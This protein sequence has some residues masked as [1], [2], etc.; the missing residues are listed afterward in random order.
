M[1]LLSCAMP[2]AAATAPLASQVRT[3]YT[4]LPW[5]TAMAQFVAGTTIKIQ[6]VTS[7]TDTGT[8]RTLRKPAQDWTVI[9][10]DPADAKRFGMT[11]GRKGLH[12]L[13]DNLPVEDAKRNTLG[14]DPSTLPFLSQRIL[15]VL[16]QLE[17]ENYSFYQRRLAEFQSR[18][19]STLEVGRSLL[20]D[21]HILDLTGATSPWVR[22]A[23]GHEARPPADLWTAWSKGNRLN[24]LTP[25]LEEAKK[26]GL[27]IVLDAWTP[28]NI[29][30][31]VVGIHANVY[32]APPP[33]DYEFFTYLHD[34]YLQIWSA[35]VRKQGR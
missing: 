32:L 11:K 6:P 24:E 8:L 28:S 23:A 33:R 14:F 34:I 7:W 10:L 12:L 17:P 15:I 5:I 3:V 1:L 18:M 22:A 29:R 4:T 9:S 26:R 30:K 19:E 16:S 31:Q 20:K 25:A 27:L 35:S 21:T 2:S 13:Y